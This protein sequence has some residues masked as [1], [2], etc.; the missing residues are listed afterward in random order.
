MQ[1]NSKNGRKVILASILIISFIFLSSIIGCSWGYRPVIEPAV[2]IRGSVG[3]FAQYSMHFDDTEIVTSDLVKPG[4]MVYYYEIAYPIPDTDYKQKGYTSFDHINFQKS[5]DLTEGTSMVIND[6]RIEYWSAYKVTFFWCFADNVNNAESIE[7]IYDEYPYGPLV[8][9]GSVKG[10]VQ[11]T[12]NTPYI[13]GGSITRVINGDG[14]DEFNWTSSNFVS[15]IVINDN[16]EG[17]NSQWAYS[18]NSEILGTR[19]RIDNGN[20]Y[21]LSNPYDN[22]YVW[23]STIAAGDHTVDVQRKDYGDHWGLIIQ[24]EFTKP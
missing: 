13:D 5:W 3:P 23:P 14:D 22:K 24:D 4:H 9:L 19:I 1:K 20:W 10:V 15:G 16:V 17:Y 2:S 8:Y 12:L 7:E 21:E 11:L 6:Y 18:R